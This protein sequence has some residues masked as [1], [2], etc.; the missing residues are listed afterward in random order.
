MLYDNV[1]LRISL[2][3]LLIGLTLSIVPLS[4]VG[5]YVTTQ[6]DRSLAVATTDKPVSYLQSEASY[7]HRVYADGRG[8]IDVGNVRYDDASKSTYITIAVP[9]REE[10]SGSFMGAVFSL[11]DVSPLF[12]P[13][14]D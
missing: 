2:Q 5:L 8:A 10:G 12:I 4:V 7:W 14:N 1:E 13:F 3:K 9:V 6:S 11:I